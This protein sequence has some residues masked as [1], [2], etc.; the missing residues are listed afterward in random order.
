[1][2]ELLLN[3]LDTSFKYRIA[4]R[5]GDDSFLN[6][7]ACGSC[8]A[9]CPVR[10]LEGKYNPRRLIRMAILGMKDEV[11]KSEFLWLCSYHSTC[12]YRCPQKVNIGA[13]S[14]AVSRL[15]QQAGKSGWPD[16]IST[17]F[18]RAVV[19][20][21]PGVSACFVCGSCT[22][23]C[24][25]SFLD[26]AND[27]RKFI[28]KVNL[29]LARAALSDEFKDI[30]ATHF[31]CESRCPQG[32]KISRVMQVLRELALEDGYSLPESIRFLRE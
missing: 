13:V 23:V 17:E 30:C 20:E 10:R 22:A 19:R 3:E 12:L 32:V 2:A 21:V 7:F 1:M 11:Y 28:R 27:P 9:S 5:M 4:E 31:R 14:D 8:T 6:C 29:G 18:R 25:E 16:G 15:K 26:P 24:P